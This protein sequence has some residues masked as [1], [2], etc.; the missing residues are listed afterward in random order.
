MATVAHIHRLWDLAD[1]LPGDFRASVFEFRPYPGSPVWDQLVRAGHDPQAM[2]A[3][4]DVDLTEHG[5]DEAMRG[6]D[7]FNFS[8]GIPFSHTPLSVVR[9][10]LAGLSRRQH[11]RNQAQTAAR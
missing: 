9:Q 3:Y 6:R 4:D 8:V 10:H 2:Q 5:A 11:A 1:Q 7:E